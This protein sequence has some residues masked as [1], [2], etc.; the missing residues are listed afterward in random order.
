MTSGIGPHE[1]PAPDE[2]IL[3]ML[4]C[5]RRQATRLSPRVISLGRAAYTS[6][7]EENGYHPSSGPNR[8]QMVEKGSGAGRWSI[9]VW[10]PLLWLL[11]IIE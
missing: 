5:W 8:F 6:D 9:W 3:P 2:Q 1:T 7:A 4:P 11:I 10:T